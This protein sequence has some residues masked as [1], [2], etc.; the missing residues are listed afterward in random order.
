MR[1]VGAITD[2]KLQRMR[3]R[4]QFDGSFRLAL[5]EVDVVCI[6]GDRHVHHRWLGIDQ[7][8]VVSGLWL[9]CSDRGNLE[10]LEAK[11]NQ[12]RR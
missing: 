9:V 4:A 3:S 11:L 12:Y 1:H 7:Q 2:Q 8:M 6:H 5:S 10:P